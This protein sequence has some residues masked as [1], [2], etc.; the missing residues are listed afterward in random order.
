MDQFL[1][2]SFTKL[3]NFEMTL[4][5]SHFKFQNVRFPPPPPFYGAKESLSD[6]AIAIR[7][8]A[9]C[10]GRGGARRPAPGIISDA[11]V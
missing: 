7:Q 6:E 8:S 2:K 4:R 10:V 9:A 11:I 1:D 3:T 5:Q